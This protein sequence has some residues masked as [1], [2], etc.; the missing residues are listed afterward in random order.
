MK[1]MI[2]LAVFVGLLCFTTNSLTSTEYDHAYTRIKS[3]LMV[4]VANGDVNYQMLK[5]DPSELTAFLDEVAQITRADYDYWSKEKRLAFLL[6]VYNMAT[7]KF[8]VKY[9]PISSIKHIGIA[10]TT[11]LLGPTTD[12]SSEPAPI[13]PDP[14]VPDPL[15]DI[16]ILNAPTE[17]PYV[18]DKDSLDL[19]GKRITL[20]HLENEIIRKEFREPRIHFALCKGT[21]GSPPLRSEPYTSDQIDQQL[22]DQTRRFLMQSPDHNY[23]DETANIVYLSP[24]FHWYAMDF[25]IAAISVLNYVRLYKPEVRNDASIRYSHYDWSLNR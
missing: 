20:D 21:K 2:I 23:Y 12:N 16:M 25:K 19:F 7:L 15:L 9:Y 17:E 14:L 11:G 5:Q 22:R 24:I 4:C 10:A 18:L 6:N 13:V 1:R 3:I 8:V